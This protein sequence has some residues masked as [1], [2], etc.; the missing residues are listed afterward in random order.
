MIEKLYCQSALYVKGLSISSE[1]CRCAQNYKAHRRE[2]FL[3]SPL[4]VCCIMAFVHQ[5]TIC[6]S[7]T[8][9]FE[10]I[11]LSWGRTRQECF[12]R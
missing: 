12:F 5:S 8:E 10:S 6:W 9:Y 3:M 11:V 2:P 1:S 4:E 7:T